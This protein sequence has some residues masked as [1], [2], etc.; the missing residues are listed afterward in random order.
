[1]VKYLSDLTVMYADNEYATPDEIV[2]EIQGKTSDIN[3]GYGG[4]FVW[5]QP[6]WTSDRERAISHLSFTK[7]DTE[8]RNYND[9]TVR[10]SA[11]DSYRYIITEREGETKIVNVA[12]LRTPENLSS[13]QILTRIKQ[14]GFHHFSTDLNQG[15]GG[16]YLYVLWA[17]ETD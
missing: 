11:K 5:L 12:L 9:I 8:I 10:V 16:D 7:S 6:E 1:M 14:S 4:R 15:R 3:S 17:Y 13:D 2:P